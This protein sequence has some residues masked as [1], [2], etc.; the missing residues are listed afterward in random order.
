MKN[1]LKIFSHL[2]EFKE[3]EYHFILEASVICPKCDRLM[4][5]KGRHDSDPNDYER[6]IGKYRFECMFCHNEVIVS[7]RVVQ[8][9]RNPNER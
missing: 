5:L 7:A 8:F 1:N 9:R 6:V 4:T 2:G 3:G